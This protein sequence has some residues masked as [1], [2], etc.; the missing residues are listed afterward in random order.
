MHEVC[1]SGGP[2]RRRWP[3]SLLLVLL[4]LPSLAVQAAPA[5]GNACFADALVDPVG[6]SLY[7]ILAQ[8]DELIAIEMQDGASPHSIY[9]L[10]RQMVLTE[11]ILRRSLGRGTDCNA[12]IDSIGSEYAMLKRT[13]DAFAQGSPQEGIEAVASRRSQALLQQIR[14]RLAQTD[15][16]V[17]QL[18]HKP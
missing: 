3:R 2:A 17:L 12:I 18:L 7:P 5:A 9:L 1:G 8:T 14:D 6:Q 4:C 13:Y 10:T 15:A 16:A 11:R